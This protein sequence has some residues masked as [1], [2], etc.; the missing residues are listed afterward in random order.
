[1]AYK[2][3]KGFTILELMIAI[4]VFTIA[5]VLITSGVI[6]VGRYYQQGATKAKLLTAAR[7]IHSQFTQV[8]QY[9]GSELD[10]S[11]PIITYAANGVQYKAT[12]I[13][14]TR[15]LWSNINDQTQRYY[16]DFMTD[17]ITNRSCGDTTISKPQH[18]L[19]TNIPYNSAI[20]T[21]TKVI[22]FLIKGSDPYT[23]TTTFV[24]GSQDMFV[25]NNYGRQCQSNVLGSEFCAVVSLTSTVA[26]KVIN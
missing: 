5:I 21:N 24:I 9:S 10:P 2:N 23:L 26:R 3:Q 1:M 15:Y 6:A 17:D 4:S 14:A 18:P 11:H 20:A 13:G 8:V 16:G 7:E 25:S 22:N 12:C 19:P